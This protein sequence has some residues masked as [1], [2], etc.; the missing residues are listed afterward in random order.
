M[1]KSEDFS[2]L[3]PAVSIKL[4]K[5]KDL[6]K[7]IASTMGDRINSYIGYYVS[8]NSNEERHIYFMLNTNSGYYDLK[9]LPFVVWV[10]DPNPPAGSFIRYH[11]SP[12]EE[13]QF[14]DDITDAKWPITI[15]IVNFEEMPKF[16]RI[17]EKK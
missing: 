8:K 10:E 2:N 6:V 9:A 11:T 4:T 16:L 15:P 13:M 17:W 3:A 5:L 7:L 14:S 1:E 12:K